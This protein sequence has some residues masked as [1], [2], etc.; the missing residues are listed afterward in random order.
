MSP[1]SFFH[2]LRVAL[3]AFLL[4]YGAEAAVYSGG[5]GIEPNPY[6]IGNA[7]DWATLAYTPGDW[8]KYFIL[9]N[10]IDFGG[11]AVTPVGTHDQPFTGAFDGDG[12]V[13]RNGR[14]LWPDTSYIGLFCALGEG[15]AL[16]DLGVEEMEV[17]G[18]AYCGG[19]VGQNAGGDITS[20][21][22]TGTVSGKIAG[23]GGLVGD[24]SDG[25]LMSCYA[26]VTAANGSAS[27]VLDYVGGLV[28][29][30]RGEIIHCHAT[31]VVSG[32]M[33]KVGGLA[34]VCSEGTITSC[35]AV[36]TFLAY[37]NYVG[38]LV[39][40]SENSSILS[41][42]S[43]G[44]VV[45]SISVGG[46]LGESIGNTVTG[47]YATGA[48]S[49]KYNSTGGL[50][51]GSNGSTISACHVTGPVSGESLTGGLVGTTGNDTVSS[52]YATGAVTGT[53]AVG[54]LVGYNN[55]SGTISSCYTTGTV[56]GEE[57]WVGGL[58]GRLNSGVV[59]T[60]YARGAVTGDY[61]VGG[62][63][64]FGDMEAEIRCCYARGTV[65]GSYSLGGLVG[66]QNGG[67]VSYCY[68][69]GAVSG[70][71]DTGG[72]VG[73]S[74]DTV[75]HSYWDKTT[76]GQYASAGGDGR[77]TVEMTYPHSAD[78]YVGWDFMKTW[79]ADS[80]HLMNDGYPYLMILH[81]ADGNKDFRLA[82][83]EAI[84]YLTGWQQGDNPM[85]HAI[86]AAYL[87]QNGEAYGYD[88]AYNPPLC[89]ILAL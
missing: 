55:Y 76:S 70:D 2:V 52:C 37:M 45:G 64:G 49:G 67:L 47:C 46:L 24:N 81:P 44:P 88:G 32:L 57:Y 38:G 29:I 21:Y 71:T 23:L 16:H 8:D 43:D 80:E 41:C 27:Q 61:E 6:R 35:Y 72:L 40:S 9:I 60:C 15:G 86:R 33:N 78:T 83:S 66:H 25:T 48:V 53:Y 84:A 51:G 56:T 18:H 82:M 79:A 22:F 5:V 89:W 54:G 34:G 4:T 20:C 39:G 50:I 1:K 19:L 14:I 68:A 17:A 73:T 59:S 77:V 85:A 10:D 30:N 12:H 26:D 3:V 69:T 7:A 42:Y 31:A 74:Y 11:A 28:G 36:G 65:T 63:V 75:D 62:L 87:W 13:L 58:V